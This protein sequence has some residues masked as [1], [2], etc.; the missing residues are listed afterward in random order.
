MGILLDIDYDGCSRNTTN[1]SF[2]LLSTADNATSLS[3]KFYLGIN[4]ANRLYFETSGFSKTLPYELR[5]NNIIYFCLANSTNV[6]YGV[7]AVLNQ[8]ITSEAIYLP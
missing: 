8:T 7:F 6:E 2:V 5:Q 4:D 3:G 1:T